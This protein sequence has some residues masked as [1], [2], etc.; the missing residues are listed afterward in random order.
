MNELLTSNM[1]M[2]ETPIQQMWERAMLMQGKFASLQAR[3]LSTG[4]GHAAAIL[5]TARDQHP[6]RQPRFRDVSGGGQH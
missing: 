4:F 5:L 1:K 3:R 2:L 6:F